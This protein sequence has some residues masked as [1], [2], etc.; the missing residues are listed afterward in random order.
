MAVPNPNLKS[1][2]RFDISF[3]ET[4][5]KDIVSPICMSK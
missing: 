4:K 2:V 3:A 1:V 5:K